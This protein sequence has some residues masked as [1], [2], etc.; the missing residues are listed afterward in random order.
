MWCG[1]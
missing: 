1:K